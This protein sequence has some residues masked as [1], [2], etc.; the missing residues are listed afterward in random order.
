MGDYRLPLRYAG[1]LYKQIKGDICSNTGVFTG[2]DAIRVIL[3]G[4]QAV[5]VV[6]TVYKN[7]VDH[8]STMLKDMETWME[9]NSYNSLEDFRGKA[10]KV[11]VKDPYAYRRA[12]YVDLLM[13]PVEVMKK[14]PQV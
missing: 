13:K 9:K 7:K 8:I 1:L 6:S 10:A 12:Q 11:N 14:Y 5:Q 2:E 4:A 3:A